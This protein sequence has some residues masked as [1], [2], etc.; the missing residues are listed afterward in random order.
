MKRHWHKRHIE[1]AIV[2][3]LMVI[4]FAVV[5]GSLILI[6]WTVVSRGLP[7]LSWQI[8]TQTPK[9]GYYLGKEGGILNAIVGSLYLAGG[10]TLLALIFGLPMA[11]YIE[12]YARESDWGRAVRLALDVLWGIPSIVYGA[13][14]FTLMLSLG[15]RA[16]LLGGILALALLELPIMTRAMDEVIRLMPRDLEQAALAL[17]STR[18]ETAVHVVTRQMLPGILTAILL[19]FGRGIGD[20]ASVLFTAG[21]TDRIPTS[22][23]RPVASLPL[24]VFFQL[25]TPYPEVQQR[26]YASALILTV[27]VLAISLG[28]RWVARRMSK[29][30]LK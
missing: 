29:F 27:I 16:S 8:L 15:L 3:A 7:A 30:T 9:G 17:G 6:L 18:L 19:A 5:A 10:G 1:E 25:G 4:S 23:M 20:A 14:G 21:Y 12:T 26:A 24:A 2:Q 13:F 22:L 28:S 11:L